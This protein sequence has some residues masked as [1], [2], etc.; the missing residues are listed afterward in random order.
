[1]TA[2]RD[3][4]KTLWYGSYKGVPFH[5]ESEEESGGRG[6]VVHEFPNRDVPFVE[7]LGAKPRN[8]S[9]TLYVHGD[10]ADRDANRL[11]EMFATRGPGTLV[12]PL[13]GPVL[14]HCEDFKR[15]HEKDKLGYVAFDAKFVRD[16]A[17]TA[18]IPLPMA[19]M[20]AF[21]AAQGMV[22][23]IAGTF[24]QLV[25][26]ADMPDVVVA[27]ASDAIATS[28]AVLDTV[29][30][31]SPVDPVVSAKLRDTFPAIV[32]A[33][34][35]VLG[36]EGSS[37]NAAVTARVTLATSLIEA[38][39]DLAQ[40]LPPEAAQAAMVD[41]ADVAQPIAAPYLAPSDR[42]VAWNT[43]EA[44]RVARLAALTAWAEALLRRTYASRQDGVT[45]RAEAAT[46]FDAELRTAPGADYAALYVA[47]QTL[48]GRVVE[49]LTRL[50][51]DLAPVVTVSA[52][53]RMPSLWWAYRL[54][55]DPQ[56]AG[57]LVG[58]NGVR[59]PGFMPEEFQAL[60]R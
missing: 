25:Q 24:A 59:H 55:A 29:R 42:A 22:A 58:R 44:L 50:I 11:A 8:H 32:A 56:R 6:L 9:G 60:A 45:A 14:V 39:R 30:T 49:Y 41:V 47:I 46:R 18:L 43:A 12:V 3:W 16:G 19:L 53:R 51:A 23:A 52:A 7:D 17:L 38:T 5:F 4:L 54:Y 31:S 28:A 27:A 35:V 2:T 15:R 1:M 13:R 37:D 20:S 10:N 21:A 36:R 40:A 26:L 57:E 34:S 48:R 33:A